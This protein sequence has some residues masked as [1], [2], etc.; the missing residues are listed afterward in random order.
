MAGSRMIQDPSNPDA[1][2]RPWQSLG[3]HD[4]LTKLGRLVMLYATMPKLHD[5]HEMTTAVAQSPM[6]NFAH[7][8]TRYIIAKLDQI[9]TRLRIQALR[10]AFPWL[11]PLEVSKMLG[12]KYPTVYAHW[13]RMNN[14]EKPQILPE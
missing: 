4:D 8:N 5:D 6:F 7:T 2:F 3:S 11:K 13:E 12:L 10:T 9:P 1:K 14:L